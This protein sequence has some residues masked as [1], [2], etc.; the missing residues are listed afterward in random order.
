VP[1]VFEELEL[2]VGALGQNGSRERLHDLLDGNRLLGEL[3]F[4]GTAGS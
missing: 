4:C 3:I 1:E 2:S